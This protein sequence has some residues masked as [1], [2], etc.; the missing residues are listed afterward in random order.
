VERNQEG[1]F[2]TRKVKLAE[3]DPELAS[4][5][6]LFRSAATMAISD[7][8]RNP[9]RK[10]KRTIMKTRVRKGKIS[11]LIL[12]SANQTIPGERPS[13]W[14]F[15]PPYRFPLPVEFVVDLP[16]KFLQKIF[17]GNHSRHL[18]VLVHHY[19]EVNSLLLQ[20]FK[21]DVQF[22]TPGDKINFP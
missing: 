13:S 4:R 17:Q 18:S 2:R 6:N 7:P 21:K 14:P 10:T 8:E 15:S 5:L 20:F 11:I 12:S 1:S 16:E 3:G 9:S 22:L 19:R